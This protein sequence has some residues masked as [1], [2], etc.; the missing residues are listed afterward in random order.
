MGL[1][2]MVVAQLATYVEEAPTRGGPP[3]TL[4][5]TV[6]IILLLTTFLVVGGMLAA[7][8]PR[9]PVGWLLLAMG[10]AGTALSLGG[11]IHAQADNQH[12]KS[13]G[14]WID[15]GLW[16]P[17]FPALGLLFLLFPTGTPPTHRWRWLQWL[18]LAAWAFLVASGPFTTPALLLEF[19]PDADPVIGGPWA[20]PMALAHNAVQVLVFPLLLLAV[21]SLTIRAL[22]SHGLERQQIKWFAAS[23]AVIAIVFPIS[24]AT[25]GD[26]SLGAPFFVLLPLACMIAVLRYRLYDI[27]RIINRTL[28]YGLL[29][30]SLGATYL[31]LVVALQAVLRPLSGGSDLAIVVTTL[32][33]AA[34]FLP[35]R[36]RLQSIVDRR[37]NRRHY[38][39]TRTVEAFSARLREQIDLDTLRSELASVVGDTMQPASASLWLRPYLASQRRNDLGTS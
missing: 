18:L 7:R 36:G 1:A 25:L 38:D 39:A 16:H 5:A 10:M 11:F 12:L 17:S 19:Y 2:V 27:D 9:H 37:F 13:L 3:Q 6:L 15:A 31:G 28:T 4:T 23:A 24:L 8:R 21:A 26:G 35:A 20:E 29:T 22:Q 33:V 30:A 32:I 14:A 34:L